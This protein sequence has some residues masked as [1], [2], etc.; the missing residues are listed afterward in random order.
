MREFIFLPTMQ[1]L[2]IQYVLKLLV[3]VRIG[4]GK[5]E[6]ETTFRTDPFVYL[7]DHTYIVNIHIINALKINELASKPNN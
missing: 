1:V 5:S 3:I 4:V 7:C 6:R 2:F